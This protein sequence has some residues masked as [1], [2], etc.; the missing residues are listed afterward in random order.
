MSDLPTLRDLAPLAL[1]PAALLVTRALVRAHQRAQS[2]KYA[3]PIAHI[4]RWALGQGLAE[5]PGETDTLQMYGGTLARFV[6]SPADATIALR[7]LRDGGSRYP[8][9]AVLSVTPLASL[10]GGV[11]IER[12]GSPN[13]PA[14]PSGDG[15]F[16]AA[17][18]VYVHDARSARGLDADGRARVAALFEQAGALGLRFVRMSSGEMNAAY[19]QGDG[20]SVRWVGLDV[21]DSLLDAALSAC[22]ALAT[23]TR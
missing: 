13:V 10:G 11:I 2:S 8:P 5:L 17:C 7:L 23:P 3:A 16:D 12:A 9:S 4:R 14:A 18:A 6:G 19:R 21:P 22:H 20:A 1:L 15:R